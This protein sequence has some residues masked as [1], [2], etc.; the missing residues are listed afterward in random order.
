MTIFRIGDDLGKSGRDLHMMNV[1]VGKLNVS[2]HFPSANPP[3]SSP[4]THH[5]S[6]SPTPRQMASY[7]PV[8]V[9]GSVV[10]NYP[11]ILVQEIVFLWEN[12]MNAKGFYGVI[13][14]QLCDLKALFC[15]TLP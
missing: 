11:D 10:D 14:F 8:P 7:F 12:V 1:R 15:F 13:N 6:L 5:V 9:S 4:M 3:L 2:R